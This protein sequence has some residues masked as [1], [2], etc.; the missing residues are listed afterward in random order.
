M[1]TLLNWLSSCFQ[2]GRIQVIAFQSSDGKPNTTSKPMSLVLANKDSVIDLESSLSSSD[3]IFPRSSSSRGDIPE[4][5]TSDTAT[6]SGS[7]VSFANSYRNSLELNES[8]EIV[9]CA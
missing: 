4:Q 2:V 1:N 6:T 7:K 3:S 9:I 8:C 5:D